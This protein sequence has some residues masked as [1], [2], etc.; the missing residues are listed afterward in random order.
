MFKRSLLFVSLLLV[1]SCAKLEDLSG[2][3]LLK[4]GIPIEAVTLYPYGSNDTISAK[5]TINIFDRLIEVDSYGN[6]QP[7]LAE[8][9]KIETPTTIRLNLRSNVTFHNGARFTAKDVEYSI[10][11]MIVAPE[12]EHISNPIKNTEI[13]DNYT[14]LVHLHKPFAPIIAHFTHATMAIVNKEYTENVGDDINQKPVGTGPY[15]FKTWNRGENLLLEANT[16]YWGGAPKIANLDFIVIPETADRVA[17]L[18]DGIIDIAYDIDG[19]Y[20]NKVNKNKNLQLIEKP[21]ARIEYLGFNIEKGKNPIWKDKRVREAVALAIDIDGIIDSVL[22]GAGTPADS[23]LYKT[24]IGHYGGLKPRTRD[25]E[26]A[27]KLLAEAGVTPGTKV[28]MWTSGDQRQKI[29]EVVQVNLREIG[30]DASIE[31]YEWGRFLDGT[32]N[33]LH[34]MFVLGWTT[35]TGDADYGIYNQV[36]TKAFGSAGNRAFYSNIE[37]DNLLDLAR[38]E[39]DPVKRDDMY[40]QIQIILYEDL[41]F[42]PIFYKLGN[43]GASRTVKG[44]NFDPS[45]SHRL[46]TVYFSNLNN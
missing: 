24:V 14:I 41:P 23:L 27:K 5:M 10:A 43:I 31:V 19:I 34:D 21:I 16:V 17:A 39:L 42:I 29:L 8:S 45:E 9:W 25:I 26:K 35:V 18:E 12:V 46:K 37:V 30:I 40:K 15:K 7:G 20:R 33:G 32:G 3:N 2:K 44:F 13:L 38:V 28:K 6:F 4:I 36:H 11:K 22:F 1:L